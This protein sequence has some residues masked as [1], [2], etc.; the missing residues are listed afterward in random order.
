MTDFK[1]FLMNLLGIL[2]TL[3][4]L[5]VIYLML[6]TTGAIVELTVSTIVEFGVLGAIAI[7]T[8]TFW[9]ADTE[10]KVKSSDKYIKARETV[11][12]EL[13]SIT[14]AND[15]D[16]YIAVQNTINYNRYMANKCKHLTLANFKPP[17]WYHIDNFFRIISFQRKL[18]KLELFNRYVSRCERWAGRLH[19]LSSSGILTLSNHQFIDDRNHAGRYKASYIVF[20]TILSTSLLLV[21]SMVIFQQKEGIDMIATFTKLAMYVVTILFN[22]ITTI[23]TA[24]VNT[25]REDFE[26]FRRIL[27]ICDGYSKFRECP[28]TVDKVNYLLEVDDGNNTSD[29]ESRENANSNVS[30]V[31]FTA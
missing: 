22:I 16:M 26:Y 18:S 25:E 2:T 5:V 27:S 24:H 28:F 30:A 6:Y 20:G 8:K 9:Y 7:Y 3:L 19:K 11:L 21:S 17:I 13:E 23:T 10:Y 1:K 14:D 4:S 12:T 15:F 31:R 29:A